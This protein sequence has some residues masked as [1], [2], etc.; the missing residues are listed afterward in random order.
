M[1][2][3]LVRLNREEGMTVII[4]SSEL[5]ELRQICDRIAIVSGG[6]IQGTFSPDESAA[7]LG[8]AMAGD[9][10]TEVLDDEA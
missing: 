1:L 4:T 8:L 7:V 3:T 10:F 2:D 9:D 5:A 6:V